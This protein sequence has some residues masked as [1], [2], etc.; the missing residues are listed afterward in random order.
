LTPGAQRGAP[1]THV[2]VRARAVGVAPPAEVGLNGEA[3][4]TAGLHD[5]RRSFV[6]I[7][8]A[9]GVT[10]PEAAMLARTPTPA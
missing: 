7:A 8:R 5:L 6:A 3:R 2:R 9:N 4:E 1:R 10:L